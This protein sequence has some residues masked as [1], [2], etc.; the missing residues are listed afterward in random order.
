MMKKLIALGTMFA[1]VAAV[2]VGCQQATTGTEDQNDNNPV[3]Q[4]IYENGTH[5][6]ELDADERGWKA[7]VEI[8]VENGN[9][10]SVD[11]DEYNEEGARKSEDE[12]YA[13]R[14]EPAA[15]ITPAAAYEFLQ[16]SLLDTQDITTIDAATGATSST[17]KFQKVVKMALGLE[18]AQE[19]LTDG[20]FTA[21]TEAD[22]RG[23]K[24]VL[25]ITVEN[26]QIVAVDFDEVN[27]E[28]ARK[29]EDEAYA[30]RM[31]A[32]TDIT[33][34]EAYEALE[35][36]LLDNQDIEAVETVTGATSSTEKFQKLVKEALG[37]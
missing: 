16:E 27:E 30:E 19:G 6:A 14:M 8:V 29:S 18:I 33:P 20:V 26:G 21:E 34:A 22:E 37:L 10:I 4:G 15:G 13:E 31:S 12:A 7:A 3:V 11:F 17:E 9:I 28:D 36:A 35:Q 32:A 23:W 1:L 2:A 25:E 24:A 5:A